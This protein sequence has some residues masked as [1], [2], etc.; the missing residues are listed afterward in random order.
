M[1][2]A[3]NAYGNRNSTALKLDAAALSKRSMNGTSLNNMVRLAANFGI[4][5][6]YQIQT[7]KTQMVKNCGITFV[8]PH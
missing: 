8:I 7:I 3:G 6:P 1:S 4:P 5:I 2:A